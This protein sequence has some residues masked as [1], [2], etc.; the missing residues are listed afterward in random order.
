M[1]PFKAKRRP[2]RVDREA[3]EDALDTAA[4]ESDMQ[5]LLERHPS[6]LA[7]TVKG[8]HG[9][10]VLRQVRLGSAY[11]PDFLMASEA[12]AGVGRHL[13]ELESPKARLTNPGN[14]RESPTLRAALHQIHDWREWLSENLPAAQ[15]KWPGITPQSRGLIIMGREDPT[16]RAEGIRDRISRESRIEIRTYDWLIRAAEGEGLAHLGLL[17][18]ETEDPD[19]S[20]WFDW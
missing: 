1:E 2:S 13:V 9:T 11:V 19:L 5:V 18:L 14:Q 12:S 3:L 15:K 17:D 20:A 6:L 10:W 7:A 8:N 16:D 4:S